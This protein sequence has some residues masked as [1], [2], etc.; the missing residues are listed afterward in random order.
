[1]VQLKFK[2]K[3]KNLKHKKKIDKIVCK[4]LKDKSHLNKVSLKFLIF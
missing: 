3:N 2:K 1:M 4:I